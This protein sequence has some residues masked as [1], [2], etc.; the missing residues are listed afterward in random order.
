MVLSFVRNRFPLE[1]E[2]LP[3]M[4]TWLQPLDSTWV[5]WGGSTPRICE[6]SH[7]GTMTSV[8][9]LLLGWQDSERRSL[10]RKKKHAFTS[11]GTVAWNGVHPDLRYLG[12]PHVPSG[13]HKTFQGHLSVFCF[14]ETP[15]SNHPLRRLSHVAQVH[16]GTQAGAAHVHRAGAGTTGKQGEG[17]GCSFFGRLTLVFPGV[18]GSPDFEHPVQGWGRETSPLPNID[19][20]LKSHV[21]FGCEQKLR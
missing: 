21:L 17:C 3:P 10:E 18:R 20:N 14:W 16:G 19:Q 13:R 15:N 8:P 5:W 4:Q 12:S 1:G 11:F 2:S 9:A 6:G 7:E